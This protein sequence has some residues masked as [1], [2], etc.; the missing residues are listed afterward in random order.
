MS[1]SARLRRKTWKMQCRDRV[2]AVPGAMPRPANRFHGHARRGATLRGI[3][4]K[5]L[6]LLAMA[7]MAQAQWQASAGTAGLNVQ[8]LASRAGFAFAGGSSGA[9]RSTDGAASFSLSNTGNSQAG[10]TRGFAQDTSYIYTCTSQGVFRSSDNGAN[11]VSKSVGLTSLLCSGILSVPPNLF[12]VGT[13]GVFRSANQGDL[14]ATAGLAGVDV[15]CI[16]AIGST[17]FAGTN[18]TGVYKSSDLGVTWTPVNNGLT[19][20]SVRALEAKGTTLFAGGQIGTGV[21]RSV[22]LGVQ[23]TLL[24]GGLPAGTYR[25]FASNADMVFAASFG[26]GA[27][28]SI[29]NGDHWVAI[30]S[31][32]GDLSLFDLEVHQGYLVAA[33]NTQGCFRFPLDKLPFA[34]FGAGCQGSNGIPSLF[35]ANGSVA[36]IGTTLQLALTNLPTAPTLTV[37]VM[38]LSR[39]STSGLPLPLDLGVLGMPSCLQFVSY[40]ISEV[41]LGAGSTTWGL[42]IPSQPSLVSLSF[43]VQGLVLDPGVNAFGATVTNAGAATVV[44]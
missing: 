39:T 35:P 13:G 18:G 32:L 3:A 44:P 25:G 23:W 34:V 28:C 43:F 17:L 10:P 27:Y 7:P 40:D 2:P 31:G 19:S 14:W 4:A 16:A 30:N 37:G 12:V 38:G 36:R 26:T 6:V 22:D 41:L 29:D 9:Y 33:T 20:S 24:G 21:F 5:V 8:A 11:W 42:P 15:R 1:R